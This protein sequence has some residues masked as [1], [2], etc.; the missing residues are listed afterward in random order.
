MTQEGQDLKWHLPDL[1]KYYES[2][3]IGGPGSFVVPVT[4]WDQFPAAV[5]RKL[6]LEMADASPLVPAAF[7]I[8]RLSPT[9][10]N[11]GEHILREM[12]DFYDKI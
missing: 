10:C 8:D 12:R 3:V 4:D 9:D 6:V 1:D 5:R 2:C 7:H 11:I